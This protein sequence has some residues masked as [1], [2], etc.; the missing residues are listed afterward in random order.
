MKDAL[1]KLAVELKHD[2]VLIE[3]N[4]EKIIKTANIK[5]REFHSMEREN[6]FLIDELFINPDLVSLENYERKL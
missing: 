1:E 2:A 5:Q 6:N 4:Y 3:N